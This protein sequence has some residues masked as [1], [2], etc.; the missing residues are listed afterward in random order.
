MNPLNRTKLKFLVLGGVAGSRDNHLRVLKKSHNELT[1]GGGGYVIMCFR[2]TRPIAGRGPPQTLRENLTS[3]WKW[4]VNG[5]KK[6]KGGEPHHPT[7]GNEH[8]ARDK[9]KAARGGE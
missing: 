2:G 1:V 6:E 4:G 8:P 9:H 5:G 3:V 7:M